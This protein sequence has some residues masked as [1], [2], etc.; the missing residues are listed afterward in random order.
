MLKQFWA[1]LYRI[2]IVTRPMP[3]MASRPHV[4]VSV[5]HTRDSSLSHS[6]LSDTHTAVTLTVTKIVTLTLV[7]VHDSCRGMSH[8]HAVTLTQLHKAGK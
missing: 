4:T 3:A 8:D 1:F 5:T 2:D 6:S 7:K